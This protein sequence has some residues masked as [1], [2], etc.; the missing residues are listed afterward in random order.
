MGSKQPSEGLNLTVISP[1][2]MFCTLY[3]SDD[4][5]KMWQILLSTCPL[6]FTSSLL[7]ELWVCLGVCPS[8]QDRRVNPNKFKPIMVISLHLPVIG[9][10]R[11]IYLILT[12]ERREFCWETL[13]KW[14]STDEK[15]IP[16]RKWLIFSDV[17]LSCLE[18]I[19]WTVVVIL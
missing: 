14:S 10:E 7:A 4:D 17:T 8:P 3:S 1:K 9:S 16:G 2:S 15:K 13:G 11:G 5:D 6:P 18:V 19:P 12:N